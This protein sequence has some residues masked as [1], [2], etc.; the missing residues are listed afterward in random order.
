MQ[1]KGTTGVE[2]V[3]ALRVGVCHSSDPTHHIPI[4]NTTLLFPLAKI[5]K[6]V[7]AN[8]CFL[9]SGDKKTKGA[10]LVF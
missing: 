6:G 9:Y 4:P 10:A 8:G 5:I 2:A 7:H 1:D 3:Q